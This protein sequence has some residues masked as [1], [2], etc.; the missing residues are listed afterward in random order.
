M[1]KI[2]EQ[3]VDD[4][5]KAEEQEEEEQKVQTSIPE[6]PPEGLNEEQ[7]YIFRNYFFGKDTRRLVEAF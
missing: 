6:V 5:K 3:A 2:P 7:L 4:S 1:V